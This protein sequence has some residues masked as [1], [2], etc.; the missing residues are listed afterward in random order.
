MVN[1]QLLKE[2]IIKKGLNVEIVSEKIGINKST[3][4]RKINNEGL[5]FSIKEVTEIA[6]ILKLRRKEVDDIFFAQ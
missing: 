6:K 4:Y 5:T 2:N 3:F 1:V